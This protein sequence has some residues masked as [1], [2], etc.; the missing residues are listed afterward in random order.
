[1][2][3]WR[4]VPCAE[5]TEPMEPPANGASQRS[6]RTDGHPDGRTDRQ[7]DTRTGP[8]R[9]GRIE[10]NTSGLHGLHCARTPFPK[11]THQRT[12][13]RTHHARRFV[14]ANWRN[15]TS[16][17]FVFCEQSSVPPRR[18]PVYLLACQTDRNGQT[19]SSEGLVLV[20]VSGMT[21]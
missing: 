19:H 14:I 11:R 13:Q 12:H 5:P 18:L 20:L 8:I 3:V 6:Q 21:D 1:M 9:P 10:D 16:G 17:I 15:N 7:T 4:G 2:C